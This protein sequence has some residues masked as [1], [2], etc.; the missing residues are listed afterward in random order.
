MSTEQNKA[1]ARRFIEEMLEED[2]HL[3][4]KDGHIVVLEKGADATVALDR[5][6]MRMALANLIENA[7]QR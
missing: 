7:A 6:S 2:R 4:E 3:F 5:A 1:L